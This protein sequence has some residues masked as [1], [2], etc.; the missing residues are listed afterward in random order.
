MSN[1][2]IQYYSLNPLYSLPVK[3]F[4]GTVLSVLN[5]DN[6]PGHYL[7]YGLHVIREAEICGVI[8]GVEQR[9]NLIIYTIDDGTGT[10]RCCKWKREQMDSPILSLGTLVVIRGF[11]G[12]FEKCRQLTIKNIDVIQDPNRELL[13]DMQTVYQYETV[14]SKPFVVPDDI[15]ENTEAIE[16]ELRRYENE[17]L[18]MGLMEVPS[19]PQDVVVDQNYF[20]SQY[21]KYLEQ[22]F[23]DEEFEYSAG[24]GHDGLSELAKQVLKEQFD[25]EPSLTDINQLFVDTVQTYL[26]RGDVVT[27]PEDKD[28]HVL[29]K[30]SELRK[31]IYRI[32]RTKQDTLDIA[33]G[34]IM[35][36]YIIA[37]VQQETPYNHLPREKVARMLEEMVVDSHLYMTKGRE[38]K[39]NH[40]SAP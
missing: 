29:V 37:K 36:E 39:A 26:K 20:Q 28:L 18:R 2:A 22:E 15:A 35:Q 14:Y 8:V 24:I 33:F 9:Y 6:R 10:I 30:D 34:G 16:K 25:R 13:H 7:L 5:F 38:Y 32:V 19:Q 23:P 40:A 4:I 21:L 3:L 11:I 12:D 31:L 17:Y 1:L 27:V